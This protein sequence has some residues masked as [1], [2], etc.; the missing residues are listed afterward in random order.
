[1]TVGSAL[2]AP[3]WQA[4]VSQLVPKAE[5]QAAVAANSV[6]INVSRAVGPAV[7]GLL[8][9]SLAAVGTAF[10]LGGLRSRLGANGF[11]L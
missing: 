2:T 5:L 10:V 7:G 1:M 9:V 4:I 11:L 3:A 6:G 8:V